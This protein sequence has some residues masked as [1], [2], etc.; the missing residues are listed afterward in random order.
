MTPSLT[1]QQR[2]ILRFIKSH[3]KDKGY[4]PTVREIGH[5]CGLS[6]SSTVWFHLESLIRSGRVTHTAR[7][8]R[9]L[10]VVGRCA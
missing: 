8:P 7:I 3:T 4:S 6:S 2:S 9:T 5:A 1:P 10:K